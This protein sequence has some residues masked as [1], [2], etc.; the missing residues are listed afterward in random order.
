MNNQTQTVTT[1]SEIPGMAGNGHIPSE[2]GG[3]RLLDLLIASLMIVI[4]SPLLF[5]HA[6]HA[7]LTQGHILADAGSRNNAQPARF[8]GKLPS[9]GLAALFSVLS[10][11]LTFAAV[12][13][14]S[15]GRKALFTAQ[16]LR[17][18][19]GVVYLE[20]T[21]NSGDTWDLKSY[22]SVLSRSVLA[23]FVSPV[24]NIQAND[25]F[26][27]FGVRVHNASMND[28]VNWM[29]DGL[30]KNLR[31]TVGFVNTD[32]LNKA[33]NNDDYHHTL[34]HLDRVFPDGIGVRMAVQ[35]HGQ[36][37]ADNVNGT[38]LFPMLCERLAGTRHSLFLLGAKPGIAEATADNM[39]L[40][41]PELKIAGTRDGYFTADEEQD[42]INQINES[43]ANVLL[44]ALGA[45]RQENWIKQNHKLLEPGLMMGVGGLFDF[46]SGRISRAP[47]WVR[48]IGL[49]WVWRLM[50][51]PRRMWQRYLVGNFTFLYRVWRE[52]TRNGSVLRPSLMTPSKES[53]L[54]DYY[55][56]LG[57]RTS[58]RIRVLNL[59]RK[60]WASGRLLG[61]LIKRVVDVIVSAVMILLLSPMLLLVMLIIRLESPGPVF[62]SQTRVGYKGRLFK[63]WK[64]RS[65]YIDADKRRAELEAQNEMQGG[66]IFK[67]KRDPRI[68]RTGRIIRKLSIDELPQLWNVFKGDMSLVGPRPALPSEVELYSVEER[69]RLYAKPG[70][71]CIWQVSGRSDI[72][73]PQQ[74]LLDEDYLYS[75]SVFTDFKLLL[76]TIPAVISGKGAY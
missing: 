65:M 45:P 10:G 74:V 58:M 47:V 33:F 30:E 46:Y 13:N 2:A 36:G 20:D 55:E 37:V 3:Q 42:V 9:S 7:L 34:N 49:E 22:V 11:R 18:K 68:T 41:Y 8:A 60:L 48:E 38:D 24:R 28:A 44:V 57:T 59:K 5:I 19:L 23:L 1:E 73:F 29:Y 66:V 25:D 40:R 76:K 53:D 15:P 69:V 27:I 67:M 50:Q 14:D 43:G 62:Y 39:K 31:T 4:T 26:H 17:Q 70:I 71:T 51:E 64:F 6:I 72:P 54:L 75:Q 52:K 63:L 56:G 32:C 12:S 61:Q 16:Q 35:M 21:T